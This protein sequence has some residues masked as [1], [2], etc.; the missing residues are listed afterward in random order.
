MKSN[1]KNSFLSRLALGFAVTWTITLFC[2]CC[3]PTPVFGQVTDY[4]LAFNAAQAQSVGIPHQAAQDGYPFTVMCWFMEPTNN[5][6]NGAFV[7]NYVSSSF[8]GWQ[9]ASSGGQLYA[10]YYRANG[11]DVGRTTAAAINDGLWHHAAF[12]VTSAGG[13][14][15][16]DGVPKQTNAWAGTAGPC[17]TTGNIYLG[18]YQGDSFLTADLDEVSIWNVALTPAQIQTYMH[19][20][21]QGTEVGLV[22]YY[23]MNEGSGTN[24]YDSTI[25]A[26]TGTFPPSPNSP[27]WIITGA[28]LQ[29]VPQVVTL[30]ATVNGNIVTLRGT[31]NPEGENTLAW[32]TSGPTSIGETPWPANSYAASYTI[33]TDMLTLDGVYPGTYNFQMVAANASG[34]NYG[35]ELSFAVTGP[36]QVATLPATVNGNSV[37]LNGTINPEGFNSGAWFN[38]GLTT[39]Y[40]NVTATSTFAGFAISTNTIPLKNLSPAT[41]YFQI[42][43]T[44]A[45]G[46]NYGTVQSFSIT[47]PPQV[48]TLSA[49][50]N[51]NSAGLNGTVNPQGLNSGIWFNWGL[52]TSY[53]NVTATST[54]AAGYANST[55]TQTLGGLLNGMYHFQ[56][57]VTNANGTNYGLDQSSRSM[58]NINLP[59]ATFW[60]GQQPVQ[61]A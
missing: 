1:S 46:T 6:G 56:A 12:V 51:G 28:Q 19:Q 38:W 23:R 42:V 14:I 25:N 48:A 57:V 21:L 17:T 20:P 40:G 39:S 44:N 47:A 30:P 43:A 24:I 8:N 37:V 16:L 52:T 2:L 10:W 22:N 60:W 45:D 5:S 4:A 53:G 11:N 50:V 18:L 13:V 9:L 54:V 32:F 41:Y 15:Y 58:F 7:G 61:A 29:E 33:S 59:R 26:D 34:T 3:V 35:V 36:P 31:I 55:N 49:T 27:T